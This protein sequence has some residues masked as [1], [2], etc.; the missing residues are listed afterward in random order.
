MRP[1]AATCRRIGW[2]I[3]LL[4]ERERGSSKYNSDCEAQSFHV[5]HFVFS[6]HWMKPLLCPS[7]NDYDPAI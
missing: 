7:I 1:S 6:Y 3:A 2:S 4:G 5:A